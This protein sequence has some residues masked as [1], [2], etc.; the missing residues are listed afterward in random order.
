[1]VNTKLRER[2]LNRDVQHTTIVTLQGPLSKVLIGIAKTANQAIPSFSLEGTGITAKESK[3]DKLNI[4][5]KI[6]HLNDNEEEF[7]EETAG[8]KRMEELFFIHE[9]SAAVRNNESQVPRSWWEDGLTQANFNYLKAGLMDTSNRRC[10]NCSGVGHIKAQCPQRLAQVLPWNKRH[11]L[12]RRRGTFRNVE[13]GKG[14]GGHGRYGRPSH[15]QGRFSGRSYRG[16][17]QGRRGHRS[18]GAIGDQTGHTAGP[19]EE[20]PGQEAG[21]N[22]VNNE[23]GTN[24]W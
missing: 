22:K 11:G 15:G 5:N 24:F 14:L 3:A 2:L 21:G 4:T 10:Y 1:M 19:S 9:E 8:A 20:L 16:G 18:Y 17:P 6:N 12:R 13:R 7:E 23:D